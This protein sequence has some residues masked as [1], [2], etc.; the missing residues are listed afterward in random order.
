MMTT[1]HDDSIMMMNP[2][3]TAWRAFN[4][5]DE[6]SED[7]FGGGDGGDGGGDGGGN[8]PFDVSAEEG[9]LDI[10]TV[11]AS[12]PLSGGGVTQLASLGRDRVMKPLAGI[13]VPSST[14]SSSST[15]GAGDDNAVPT[16]TLGCLG[17]SHGVHCLVVAVAA[18][19]TDAEAEAEAEVAAVTVTHVAA[20]QALS[21]V[22]KGKP[23]RRFV[24]ATPDGTCGAVVESRRTSFVY[25]TPPPSSS[26][27]STSSSTSISTSVA[28]T[29]T[30]LTSAS[31]HAALVSSSLT[32]ASSGL[33]QILDLKTSSARSSSSAAGADHADA[34][35]LGARLVASGGASTAKSGACKL[36]LL[37]RGAVVTQGIRDIT[38]E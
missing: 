32:P 30:A 25:R 3:Y 26:S 35:V 24:L 7:E 33:H 12:S 17:V 16:K 34:L 9:P 23:N 29:S 37:T 8:N 11:V 27:T 14:P 15:G 22:A 28:T 6:D 10:F 19:N 38:R 13:F 2:A 4:D 31:S 5:E 21:Y 18:P 20:M 36:V 1:A